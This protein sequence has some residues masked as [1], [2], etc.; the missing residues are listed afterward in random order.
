MT[1]FIEVIMDSYQNPKIG[2]TYISPA[3]SDFHNKEKK[4]RIATKALLSTG[5]WEY[6]KEH[7]EIILRKKTDAATCIKAKFLE[8]NRQTFVLTIQKFIINDED[9]GTPYGSGFSF[10]GDEIDK[11]CEF[12]HHIQSIKLKTNNSINISDEELRKLTLTSSQAENLI[13]DNEELFVEVI[14]HAI[15]K[16]DIVTIAYRKKQLE[17]FRKLQED[18]EYFN[19]VKIRKNCK[20]EALWQMF[21]EKNPWIF[22]YGLD[23]I[24]TSNLDDKRLEQV[25]HGY[26]V[27][28]HGKRV[29]ALLK[30]RAFISTL[31]F[32]EIKTHRTQ[33][34]HNIPYRSGCWAPSNELTGAIAQIQGTISYAQESIFGKLTLTDENGF[35]TKEDVFNFRP[36][37][38]I[39]IGN[40]EQFNGEYGINQE[41]IRSFELYRQNIFQPE[42]I[43]FDEL[44]ERAKY[45]IATSE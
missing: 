29:D 13:S 6:A 32:V 44:Y 23:Y 16:K 22:G 34:L 11:F 1:Q 37:A 8:D 39:V 3:L 17:T 25:V 5:G 20:D 38:F 42:I 28:Q 21:F 4:I 43:T 18:Q 9:T 10:V 15:T 41:H 7:D 30:T 26:Q 27:S 40:L 31:C 14:R 33:L 36:R 2:K 35:P 19:N 45:I 12:L 24:Y